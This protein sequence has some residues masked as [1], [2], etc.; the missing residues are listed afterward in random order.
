MVPELSLDR[1]DIIGPDYYAANG[2]PHREWALLRRE[3][4]IYWFDRFAGDPFWAVT[5]HEDIVWISRQP[6]RF[7]V[8]VY[9][10]NCCFGRSSEDRPGMPAKS[11]CAIDESPSLAGPQPL[12]D[13]F[14]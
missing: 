2:Y 10:D 13:L 5:K 9:S 12:D 1:V 8:A 11:N 4:P 14:E 6:K 7:K 3:A